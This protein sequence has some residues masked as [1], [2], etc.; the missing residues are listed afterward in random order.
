MVQPPW[1]YSKARVYNSENLLYNWEWIKENNIRGL[2][3]ITVAFL[4][5]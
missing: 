3:N 5:C 1:T 4:I 2:P